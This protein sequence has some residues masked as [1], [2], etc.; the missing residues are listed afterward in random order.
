MSCNAVDAHT[1]ANTEQPIEIK[2]PN[3]LDKQFYVK[4]YGTGLSHEQVMKLYTTYFESTKQGSND[5]IGGLG[6]GS[7]SPFAYT[8]SFTVESR[9]NGKIRLYAAYLDEQNMPAISKTSEENTNEKNGLTIGFP[10]NPSDFKEFA[11]EAENLF[12]SF[13]QTPVIKGQILKSSPVGKQLKQLL[14]HTS[15]E[16]NLTSLCLSI[17]A[18]S[19]QDLGALS[20][21]IIKEIDYEKI[22][23][24]IKKR[25]PLL[26]DDF[27]ARYSLTPKFKQEF[28]N[29]VAWKDSINNDSLELL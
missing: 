11:K 25:Y 2:L 17:N 15:I 7:K 16:T 24:R 20:T 22:H 21:K 6:V 4:D 28:S 3:E 9:Q 8:D 26:D 27:V 19:K 1:E 18:F 14:N 13:K 5:F 10:V 12:K 29:Y 23:G